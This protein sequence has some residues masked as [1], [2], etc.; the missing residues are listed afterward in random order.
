MMKSHLQEGEL[1]AQDVLNKR[2][3]DYG[4]FTYNTKYRSIK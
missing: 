2:E 3:I 4:L 1:N